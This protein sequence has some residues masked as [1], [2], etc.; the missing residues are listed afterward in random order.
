MASVV[1]G[2][3]KG[4]V[5]KTTLAVLYAYWLAEK[6]AQRVCVL[7]LDSQCN[8]SK[9]LAAHACAVDTPALFR[10]GAIAW[11]AIGPPLTLCPGSKQ[12]IDLEQ[13]K[14]QVLF[15]AFRQHL[16]TLNTRYDT[17]IV[18]TPPSP[19]LR[20]GAA[21]YAADAV[22]CPIELEEFSLV[23]VTD[24]LKTIFGMRDQHN[25]GLRLL[26]IV[27]NRFNGF[28]VR[29]KDALEK[30]LTHYAEFVIPRKIS[31]RAAIPEALAAGIP[32][33]RLSKSSAREAS[34]EVLAVFE[35]LRARMISGQPTLTE[36][37][38]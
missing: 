22:V 11:P 2:N 37:G 24:M 17:V 25:P 16:M 18:D 20:L 29:Q 8:S 36:A 5:G 27:A 28:S 19:G 10:S 32:V 21:L 38:T 1:F 34:A 6:Q 14:A 35:L 9:A 15:P 4:G 26:G 23:G 33:W 31:T 12:L 30:L 7:D 13:G 3:Q